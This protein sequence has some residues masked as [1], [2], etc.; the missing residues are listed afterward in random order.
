MNEESEVKPHLIIDS[1]IYYNNEHDNLVILLEATKMFECLEY[2][3]QWR[4]ELKYH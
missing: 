1:F 4:T 2:Y 3:W